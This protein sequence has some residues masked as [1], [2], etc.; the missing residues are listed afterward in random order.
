MHAH[1]T[2]EHTLIRNGSTARWVVDGDAGRVH[3]GFA[4]N[5]GFAVAAENT[6][7]AHRAIPSSVNAFAAYNAFVLVG[8]AGQKTGS[9]CVTIA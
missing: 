5:R 8:P 7:A 1:T 2:R 4:E 9:H 3:C 6:Y